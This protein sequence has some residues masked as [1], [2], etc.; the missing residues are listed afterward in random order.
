ML[1]ETK[2]WRSHL[3]Q[4]D[5][6]GNLLE[7]NQTDPEG[8][9]VEKLEY[10]CLNHLVSEEDIGKLKVE[11]A[12]KQLKQRNENLI[13]EDI[14]L[15]INENNVSE[16]IHGSSFVVLSADRPFFA[17]QK[18]LN[19]ECVKLK[20][21]LLN[22]GY[23]AGD[24][25]MGPLVIPGTTSCL[26]CNGFIDD[27]NYYLKDRDD[28]A[29]AFSAHFKSPSFACLNSL[30]SCMASYEIVKLLL[31]FG[32]CI[33]KNNAIWINPLDFSIKKIYCERSKTCKVCQHV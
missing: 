2:K 23:S 13:I 14:N 10:D 5:P 16:L 22:V 9:I 15:T 31:G 26:A 24:G 29:E 19:N 6:V 28:D 25:L 20:I 27:N 30:V 11:V 7:M 4:F 17:I 8:T 3:V 21:P 33:T 32:E 12:A 1:I 18:W